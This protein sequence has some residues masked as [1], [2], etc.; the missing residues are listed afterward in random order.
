MDSAC[1]FC[2]FR[3]FSHLSIPEREY[4]YYTYIVICVRKDQQ[5]ACVVED[6]QPVFIR[7]RREVRMT[8]EVDCSVAR[9]SSSTMVVV[10]GAI[11]VVVLLFV[12]TIVPCWSESGVGFEQDR[13]DMVDRQ[14]RDRG[15]TAPATLGAMNAVPRH[16]FVPD[17]LQHRAYADT[18][19]PIGHGQTISQ[20]YIVAYMTDLLAIKPHHAVLEVGTGSGYQA[21]VLAE[22]TDHVYSM[23]IIP[24][25]ASSAG[26]RLKNAGYA[27]VRVRQGDGYH[28]WPE[29]APFDAI[30][31]TAA[32]EFIPP[33]LL[34]QLREGGRMIIPVGS[35]F[36]V[37]HLMLVEKRNHAVTTRSLM[38]VRFVPFR[39][40]P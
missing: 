22:L 12:G 34:S 17:T 27:N 9:G 1:N 18:P 14:I 31:V 5:H 35:P 32:A 40:E 25:L 15:I 39:R 3:L 13:R 11:A 38:P 33:P 10:A 28:G 30:I 2:I 6:Q 16:L 23:E 21:A 24:E 29:A 20:P 8:A 4:N 19:L 37:Q 7:N 26:R 36:F